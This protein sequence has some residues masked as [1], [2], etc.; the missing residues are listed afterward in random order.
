MGKPM[1]TLDLDRTRPEPLY[2][3]ARAAIVAAIQAGRAGFRIGDRLSA[4]ALSRQNPIHRNTLIRVMDDL[5]CQGYL[6]RLPNRGFEVID[7]APERPPLLTRH[8]LSISAV[9]R[10]HGL[11]SRS[12]VIVEG[13]VSARCTN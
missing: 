11:E 8:L 6:R 3:Q 4:S 9:L 12:Q 5:V 10:C 13:R 1:L 2:M 7:Q